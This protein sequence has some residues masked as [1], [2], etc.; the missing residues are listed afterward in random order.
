MPAGLVS[1]RVST[2]LGEVHN[3]VEGAEGLEELLK[4]QKRATNT[5]D[6]RSVAAASD[7]PYRAQ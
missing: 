1:S 3:N 4:K 7:S 2:Q 5:S 6:A